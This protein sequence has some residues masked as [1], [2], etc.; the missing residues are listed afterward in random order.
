MLAQHLRGLLP[1]GKSLPKVHACHICTGAGLGPATLRQDWMPPPRHRHRPGGTSASFGVRSS[2]APSAI[3]MAGRAA[4]RD[5]AAHFAALSICR[6]DGVTQAAA[7]LSEQ[8]EC[9]GILRTE[10]PEIIESVCNS[11]ARRKTALDGPG[12][13]LHNKSENG[14]SSRKNGQR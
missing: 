13:R 9:R 1:E 7:R 12:P 14:R 3:S 10:M 8:C 6:T 5:G 11:S 2:A 4:R